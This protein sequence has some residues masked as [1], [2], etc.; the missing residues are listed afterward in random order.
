MWGRWLG[1]EIADV[2]SIRDKSKLCGEGKEVIQSAWGQSTGR[3]R[4]G[5]EGPVMR[6]WELPRGVPCALRPEERHGQ[7]CPLGRPQGVLG[8]LDVEWQG[9][10]ERGWWRDCGEFPRIPRV[11]PVPRV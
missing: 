7:M 9:Q 4:R 1:T 11:V 2:Q 8:R 5:E 10:E 3:A 6:A